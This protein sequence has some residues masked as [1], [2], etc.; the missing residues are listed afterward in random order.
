MVSCLGSLVQSCCG[1]GGALQTDIPV[2]G[3]HSTVFRP[4]WV[5]PRSR[6]SALPA[7]TAQAPGCFIW[8]RPCVACSSSFRVLHKSANSVGPAFCSFPARAVQAAR[9]LRGTRSPGAV[10][11][12]PCVVPASVSAHQL[13]VCGLCLFLGS[14]V[15]AVTFLADVDHPESQEVFG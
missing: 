10:R 1:E 3:E 6:V 12:L 14:L 11:L 4:H 8:S 15:L 2:W 9:S 13:G 7:Y 5:C